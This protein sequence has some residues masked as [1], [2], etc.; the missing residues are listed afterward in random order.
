MLFSFDHVTYGYNG[1]PVVED[2]TF[3][4]HEGERVG[5][6]GGNGEGKTTLLRLLMGEL[7]PDSGAVLRKNKLNIGYLEQTGGFERTD[8][9][10]SAMEEVFEEDKR[11]IAS[12]E[13]VQ[14]EMSVPNADLRVLSAR[15]EALQK[16]I[17]SRDS[18]NFHVKIETVL[19]GMGFKSFYTREIP[20]MSGGEKTKLKL[21]RLL[22]EQPELLVLDE[23]TNHLDVKTLFW[24]EEFLSS[25]KGALLVVSHDRYFLDRLTART[26]ELEHG[27]LTSYKGNYSRYKVLKAERVKELEREYAKQQEEIAKLQT[28]IDKNIVR[29]TTA[30]S[31]LSRVNK[32]ERME[33]VEKPLLPPP[34]PR[35]SFVYNEKPYEKVVDTDVFDLSVGGKTLL[36]GVKFTLM[37]GR[38]CAIVGDN[39][40]GKTTFLKFLLSRDPRVRFGKFTRAAYYDQENAD[41][42]PEDRVLDAFW[43]KYALMSQTDARKLLA[44]AGLD[45]ED[46]QKKVKELSGG[47]RAKL[48]LS[49]LEAKRGNFI[50]L[51]EPTNHLDLPA[52]E[53]LEEALNAFDGTVLFVS[54]DRRF[55]EA[56]ADCICCLENGAMTFFDGGYQAFLQSRKTENARTMSEAPPPQK[57][58]NG[59]RSKEERAREARI[60][61]RTK[62]I[63]TRL[64]TLE[65]EEAALNDLLVQS[66]ADYKKA[67]EISARLDD[68]HKE[69]DALYAEYETLI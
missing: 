38:K 2:V 33:R 15:A 69:T 22:L 56:V 18:Y 35:F 36:K 55:I 60:R 20:T 30:K 59:Y 23:P 47:L 63:E 40:T 51:D 68:I 26:L 24:L 45:S 27:R 53:S 44:Q 64:E 21:C 5:L 66:A 14:R 65:K 62:E 49:L 58:E 39:G 54:H 9:V 6:L 42:G 25:F 19:N 11:L 34:P 3:E 37:R 16:R 17:A 61:T 31:A 1:E 13:E 28:Y 8:D 4:L 57:A 41:L 29:A 67:M 7:A 32:L 10:Y 12:L 52:R 50:V 48:E 46:V 43:S